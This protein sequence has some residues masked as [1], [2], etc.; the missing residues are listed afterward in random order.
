MSTFRFKDTVELIGI[1][2]IVAS[3]IFVGLQ[4]RQEQQIAIVDTYGQLSQSNIDLTLQ[5]GEQM[6]VWKKGLDGDK[7][8]E[9]EL[10][11]FSALAAAVVEYN[12]RVFIRWTRLGPFDPNI[13]ASRFAFALYI[14]PGLRREFESNEQF[15]SSLGAAVGIDGY[16]AWNVAVSEYLAKFDREKPA[17]PVN[18]RYL[19]WAY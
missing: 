12:K 1:A 9:D 16:G 8:T 13:A 15:K 10:D 11:R 2:A 18:K 17:I 7:L 14:Y 5:M 6:D 3:L 4:I 19:F